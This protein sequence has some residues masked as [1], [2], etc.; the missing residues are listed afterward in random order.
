MGSRTIIIDHGSG[1]LKAGLSGW[2]EPQMVL[3]SIVNYIPCRENPGPSYARRRVSLGID[4]CHPDTFS[5]PIE[6]GRVLNW[7]GVEHI[8]SFVLEKHR[9]EHEDSPVI[10]TENPLREPS[11][12]RKTLEIMFELLDVPSLLL[13]DQLE[14]SLYASGLLTGVVVDSGYGLTRVKSFHLG[15]PLPSSCKTLEFAGQD[16][17]AYLF[18][19]LFKEDSDRHNLF[20]LETVATTQISKCYVPQ[21]LAEALDFRQSLPSGSDESNTYQLP[22]G[23]TVE[24]TPLQRLAP[25]MFFSPQVFDLPGPSISQAFVESLET[26]DTSMHPLLMSHVVA[27][28]GNTLYPGF[29]KRLYKELTTNHFSSTEAIIWAGSNRNFSVWLGASMVAH[30]STYRSKWMT[31]EEYDESMRL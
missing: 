25:E 27:C 22:D 13:A 15:L 28:G 20:Q 2:N 19:S 6:R 7:E 30:L 23:T 8:W 17:S 18:K 12:R 14:M 9:H 24:L 11:D 29:T 4:F 31:K 16:L 10:I 5:Y 1:F 21:N 26:C 3:P